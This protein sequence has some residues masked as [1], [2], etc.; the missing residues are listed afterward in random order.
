MKPDRLDIPGTGSA[1][2]VTV[3]FPS[4]D[5]WAGTR[6]LIETEAPF[7]SDP[8]GEPLW[9]YWIYATLPDGT[10]TR[11]RLL[12]YKPLRA[13]QLRI[14]SVRLYANGSADPGDSTVG[15]SV[16]LDWKPGLDHDIIL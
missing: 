4:R 6:T 10:V 13:G 12:L 11:T 3:N 7:L 15:V 1:C 9:N 14:I 2:F 16:T 5:P 8:A